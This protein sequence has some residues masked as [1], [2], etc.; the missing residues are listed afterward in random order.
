[1]SFVCVDLIVCRF[2]LVAVGGFGLLG[3]FAIVYG[4]GFLQLE[5]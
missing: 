5:F 4:Y 1:M 3:C 2:V